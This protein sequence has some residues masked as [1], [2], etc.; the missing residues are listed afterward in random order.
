MSRR[1]RGFT[2]IEL[3]VAI[4]LSTIILG[5]VYFSLSVALESWRYSSDEMALQYV[6]S[7]LLEEVIEGTDWTPGLRA[8]LEITEAWEDHVG[9]VP[10]WSEERTAAGAG[11]SFPLSQFVKPGAGLPTA[12]MRLPETNRFRPIVVRWENPDNYTERPRVRAGYELVPGSTVRFGYHPDPHRVPEAIMTL[13]WD[14]EAQA[15]FL[16]QASGSEPLGKNPFGVVITDCRVRYYDSMNTLIVEAGDVQREDLPLIA[17]VEVQVTGRLG[18]H[19]LTLVG[20]AMLR[21]S[22]RHSG[23]VILRE[24]LRVPLPDS[25]TVQTFVL[26]N[27][28]GV[29]HEDELQLE[30]RPRVGKGWRLTVRFE[31]YGQARPVIAQ[32]MV[33]YPAGHPLFTDRPRISADLGL[34]LLT[35]GPGGLYDY[36]DDPEVE[37]AVLVEGEPVLLTVTK[38]D[39]Q[40]A[41][42]FVQP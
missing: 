4:S 18:A 31:R 24:G 5:A 30:I 7:G 3:L 42:C 1:V 22:M 29:D 11:E 25:R 2:L 10:P 12:E 17:A 28:T 21:N 39:L 26:T 27:L 38:M 13:R 32:V 36:D 40:G 37:D 35:I 20:M 9:F 34:D 8:A 6:M 16:D 41:A 14:P 15:V 19:T 23:L 33:E